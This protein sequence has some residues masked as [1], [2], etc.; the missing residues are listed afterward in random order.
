M[1]ISL[2]NFRSA[3]FAAQSCLHSVLLQGCPSI[4]PSPAV[5]SPCMPQ[6]LIC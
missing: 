1:V 2:Q 4:S 3:H 5:N 6:C